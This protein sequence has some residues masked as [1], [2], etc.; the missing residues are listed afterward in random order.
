MEETSLVAT[1]NL[2][3]QKYSAVNLKRKS[4]QPM[5]AYLPLQP[6]IA[7]LSGQM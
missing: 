4:Q 7:T 2:P 5:T 1:D 6:N 3:T